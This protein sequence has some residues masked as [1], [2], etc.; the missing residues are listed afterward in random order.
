MYKPGLYIVVLFVSFYL[1]TYML[2]SAEDLGNMRAKK[3]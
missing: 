2:R 1:S 3:T